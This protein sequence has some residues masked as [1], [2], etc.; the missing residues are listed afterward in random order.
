MLVLEQWSPLN[1]V[2]GENVKEKYETVKKY[3]T[4]FTENLSQITF[5]SSVYIS[6][7]NLI[8]YYINY[9]TINIWSRTINGRY[10]HHG[11]KYNGD[12]ISCISCLLAWAKFIVHVKVLRNYYGKFVRFRRKLF[13]RN[14][15]HID[16]SYYDNFRVSVMMSVM[17]IFFEAKWISAYSPANNFNWLINKKLRLI[18]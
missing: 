18:W 13:I 3:W 10:W 15:K 11:A 5:S 9:Q 1:W 2:T 16:Q 17:F 14:D 4:F 12:I 7:S 8:N 6:N